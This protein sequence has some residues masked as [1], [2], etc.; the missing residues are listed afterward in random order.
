MPTH[1]LEV[2]IVNRLGLHAR[3]SAKLVET[4]AQFESAVKIGRGERLVNARSIMSL[5]MLGAGKGSKLRLVIEGNDAD[6]AK[7]AIC[8]LIANRFGEPD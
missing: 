7:E 1:D 5:M 8:G 4:I 6:T 2:D 3:A